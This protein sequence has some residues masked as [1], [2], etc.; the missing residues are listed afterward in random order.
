[1]AATQTELEQ[2][3]SATESYRDMRG[4][5]H[6]T[7]DAIDEA[8]T[9]RQ[10]DG[11]N[12]ISTGIPALDRMLGGLSGSRL[13]AVPGRPGLGKTALAHQIALC[14]ARNGHAVGRCDLE[15]SYHEIGTRTAAHEYGISFT[16]L[17]HGYED[18]FSEFNDGMSNRPLTNL[19]IYM[20]AETY[21]L[22]GI[23]GRIAEWKHKH[24][25]QL[26]IVDH[27]QLIR[28]EGGN[29]N[30]ALGNIT[31]S[32]KRTAKRLGIPIILVCQLSRDNVKQGRR[33]RLEDLR[34]S[35]NIEQDID[36]AV[37]INADPDQD[38]DG[39]RDVELGL[40]KHRQGKT[41]WLTKNIEFDG[42]TQTFREI[43]DAYSFAGTRGAERAA[44]EA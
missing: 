33:P 20:D 44:G 34:D 41:G 22:G 24:D 40:I 42:R 9:R 10:T 28:A 29:R 5:L 3:Q 18:A 26:A 13:Y 21:H 43:T 7:L 16:A 38:D 2:V 35:G 27:L 12:G 1:L 8:M 14:A 25:I 32:L 23:I 15:M 17:E 19:P 30:E 4:V 36:I 6:D 31:S 39:A 11:L 37:A